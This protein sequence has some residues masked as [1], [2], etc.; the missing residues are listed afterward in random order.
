MAAFVIFAC[1]YGW[2]HKHDSN[3]TLGCYE[4]QNP[5]FYYS[6]ICPL[7]QT[8]AIMM[9][10]EEKVNLTVSGILKVTVLS[11]QKTFQKRVLEHG[12]WSVA[13]LENAAN[14][15]SLTQDEG[16]RMSAGGN[17]NIV[18]VIWQC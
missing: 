4:R 13:G 18:R 6:Y 1:A 9:D 3:L 15:A 10:M 11:F 5:A 16:H 2:H 8:M 12:I 7:V 14:K 17:I